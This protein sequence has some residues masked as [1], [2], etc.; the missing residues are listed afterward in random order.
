MATAEKL[1]TVAENQE[2]VYNAGYEKGKAEGINYDTFWDRYQANGGAISYYYAFA[3]NRFNAETFKPKYAIVGNSSG[4]ALQNVF[5]NSTTITEINVDIDAR[6]T[7]NIGALFYNCTGLKT[8]K[9]L[10][11][12]DTTTNG[13][14]NAFYKCSALTS[15]EIDGTIVMNWNMDVCPLDKKSI[16]SVYAALST[17]VSGKTCTLKKTA[18]NAAFTD[19]EWKALTDAKDNWT[20][21]LV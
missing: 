12:D 8:V 19:E 18:V 11:V 5:Y 10:F 14:G 7:N 1:I 3:F 15:I 13:G 2:K 21:T 9:K 20:F 4:S 17:S 16:E 6:N